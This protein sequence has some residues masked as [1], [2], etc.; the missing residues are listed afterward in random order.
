MAGM[1]FSLRALFALTTVAA[2]GAWCVAYP[3]L[4]I[5]IAFSALLVL[6]PPAVVFVVMWAS[7]ALVAV[8]YFAAER[9]IEACNRP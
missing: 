6:L 8:L 7:V 4:A 5:L 3:G 9:A 1:R 2:L